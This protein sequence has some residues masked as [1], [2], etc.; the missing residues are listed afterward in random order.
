MALDN[1]T[2]LY[3]KEI[4]EEAI[5]DISVVCAVRDKRIRAVE[6][7]VFNGYGASIKILFALHTVVIGLLIKAVFF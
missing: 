4:V 1:E 6:N 5:E 2:K 3:V 7:K